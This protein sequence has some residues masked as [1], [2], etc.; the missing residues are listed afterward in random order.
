MYKKESYKCKVVVLQI[1]TYC[2]LP[3]S[4]PS[5]SPSPLSSLIPSEGELE[6]DNWRSED[7]DRLEPTAELM[8]GNKKFKTTICLTQQN[9]LSY[10]RHKLPCIKGTLKGFLHGGGRPHIGEITYKG[11]AYLSSKHDQV[12]MRDYMNRGVTTLTW[13]PGLPHFLLK[14]P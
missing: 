4:L 13:F 1:W 11:S 5:A 3:F 7:D 2:F 8:G 14:R 6:V 10:I 9:R 12:M